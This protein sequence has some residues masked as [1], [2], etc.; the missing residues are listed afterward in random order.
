VTQFQDVEDMKYY[1]DGCE[2]HAKLKAFA[3]SVHQVSSNP[4]VYELEELVM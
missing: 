1:D 2:T 3:K 4:A